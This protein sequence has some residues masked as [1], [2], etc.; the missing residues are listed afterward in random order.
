M[1]NDGVRLYGEM[2]CFVPIYPFW[3]GR[4]CEVPVSN[5][6][7]IHGKSHY[8]LERIIKVILDLILV[9]LHE[10]GLKPGALSSIESGLLS[11]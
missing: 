4:A 10:D 11:P 8:G 2:N 9:K 7:R 1:S 5:R 6:P 3:Q